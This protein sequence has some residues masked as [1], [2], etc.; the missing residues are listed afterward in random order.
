MHTLRM[1]L[2]LS[3]LLLLAFTVSARAQST[4]HTSATDLNGTSWQLVKFQSGNDKP[5][6]PKDSTK[7]T[8]T[9][10]KE[11]GVS[12]RIDCNRGH[13]SW[14]SS[15]PSQLE[16]GPMALTRAMCPPSPITDRLPVDWQNICTYT[17]KSRHLFLSLNDNAGTYE[18]SP[19]PPAPQ[20]H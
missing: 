3:A 9:F 1:R 17:I 10:D 6:T 5:L 13:T 19:I 12:L 20:Q 4:T 8:I 16:F 2:P 11:H 14:K 15:G 18:F 7:Y